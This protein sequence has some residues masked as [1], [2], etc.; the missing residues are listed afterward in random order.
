[1]GIFS[2][3]FLEGGYLCQTLVPCPF[4]FISGPM[5]LGGGYVQR[6]WVCPG[7]GYVWKVGI[8]LPPI[9]GTWDTMGC[10][11]QVSST[12]PTGMLSCFHVFIYLFL[13]VCISFSLCV[14]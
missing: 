9:H 2:P 11:Q 13:F 7:G 12:H 5:S 4:P 8:H 6:G 10:G 1:M 3:F 14:F